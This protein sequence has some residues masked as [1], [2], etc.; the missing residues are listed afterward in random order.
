MTGARALTCHLNWTEPE[1]SFTHYASLLPERT[2]VEAPPPYTTRSSVHVAITTNSTFLFHSTGLPMSS[3]G[4]VRFSTADPADPDT[5]AKEGVAVV[6]LALKYWAPL[7]RDNI[8][9]CVITRG[10]GES[11][12]HLSVRPLNFTSEGLSSLGTKLIFYS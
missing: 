4:R 1:Y 8:E 5:R 11:G 6:D 7:A 10:E 2:G 9:V 12:V 3:G